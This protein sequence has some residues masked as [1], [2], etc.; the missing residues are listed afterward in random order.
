MCFVD[1]IWQLD[2]NLLGSTKLLTG[3]KS[4]NS[5][6]NQKMNKNRVKIVTWWEPKILK[7]LEPTRNERKLMLLLCH[8]TFL[9]ST[10]STEDV[11]LKDAP[12]I[13]NLNRK[14]RLSR[15]GIFLPPINLS[16]KGHSLTLILRLCS[17]AVQCSHAFTLPS[18]DHARCCLTS[19]FWWKMPTIPLRKNSSSY[20]FYLLWTK[21]NL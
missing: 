17:T 8:G 9:G 4:I 20:K 1:Y 3:L 13:L 7:F 19:L 14:R 18:T 5:I 2:E 6:W 10:A 21:L 12:S 11:L 15:L 16:P